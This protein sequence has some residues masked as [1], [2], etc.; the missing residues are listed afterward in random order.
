MAQSPTAEALLEIPPLLEFIPLVSPQF[1]SPWH[2]EE[3]CKILQR[4]LVGGVRACCSVPIRHQKTETSIHGIAW[5]LCKDP[6]IQVIY[7][8]ADERM[9][10]DRANRIRLVCEAAAARFGIDIG[11]ERG[12]NV[13]T[14]WKNSRGGGV[15]VMSAKQSRQGADVDVLLFDDPISE[16]DVFDPAI[17]E[18]VDMAIAIYTAR[19]GR[20][21]RRG[22][23][24]GV[25]SRWHPDDPIGRRKD[26][27]AEV[28]EKIE[29][30]AIAVNDNGDEIAFAPDV[31]DLEEL[32]KR[33][34]ELRE[35]DPT[36]RMWWANFQNN[37]L[38]DTI[39]LF[40]S[41]KRFDVLPV[42]GFRTVIGLDMAYSSS[43]HADSFALVVLKIYAETFIENGTQ[44]YGERAYVVNVWRERWDPSVVHQTILM[45]RG[46]YPG[47]VMYSYMA[48]P[49][50]GIA[51]YLAEKGI[52]IQVMP[53]RYSK[54][55]RAQAAI[56]KNNAGRILVPEQAPWVSGFVSRL[57]LFSGL[58]KAGNDDEVDALVSAVDG[59]MAVSQSVPRT[60][61]R[62]RI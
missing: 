46:M 59:G 23:V 34:A 6:T 15:Q 3:W 49:E 4:C 12:Q 62:R 44:V 57:I 39:G 17:R 33:R 61:G 45:A 25:M 41:P 7:M 8:V 42:G 5:L 10:N 60:V 9:A 32:H 51:H 11:P 55:Q 2:L 50:V 35:Q 53:A 16:L 27:V 22:S 37:P 20:P 52:P 43:A 26:R 38:P 58:E 30:P 40:K 48:G 47:A 13:K 14:S 28:W 56:D 1:T 54:R 24:A 36:E 21:S 31:M 18:R 19:A 29:R